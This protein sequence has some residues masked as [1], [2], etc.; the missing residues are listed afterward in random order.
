MAKIKTLVLTGYGINCEEETAY[1]FN[2]AGADA[3][4][5]HINDLIANRAILKSCHILVF[6]GGFSYGDDTGSGRALANRIKNNLLDEMK[7]FIERDTLAL[8]ICNGFQVM[9]KLGILPY[10]EEETGKVEVA[11]EHNSN[12][13]FQCR[14]VNLNIE[15]NN[16]SVFTRNIE[17]LYI[18]V[19]HGEG[20]FFAPP[21]TLEKIESLNLVTM[22]YSTPEG[23]PAAG[24]FPCNPNGSMNDIASICSKNG[25]IMGMMP[26]PERGMFF[27]Q[28]YDWTFLKEKFKR[29]GKD[30]PVESDGMKIFTNAVDYFK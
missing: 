30:L 19:A 23:K 11:L 1:A 3:E 21:E 12:N 14:W 20:S 13:R 22:K 2:L 29:E 6:P 10:L 28:R 5:I 7:D 9:V 8:G 25:R 16:P 4:I 15:K 17:N 24:E 27:T 18:P 26:H